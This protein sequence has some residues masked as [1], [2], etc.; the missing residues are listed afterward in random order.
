[1]AVNRSASSDGRRTVASA[2]EAA[3]EG[4]KI[5]NLPSG[6]TRRWRMLTQ[7]RSIVGHTAASA[8]VTPTAV[9]PCCS[10]PYDAGDHAARSTTIRGRVSG[11]R[12]ASVTAAAA[13]ASA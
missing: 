3:R 7:L 5:L 8:Q 2:A 13:L 10:R 1:M 9:Y 6:H 4:V 12:A 11:W